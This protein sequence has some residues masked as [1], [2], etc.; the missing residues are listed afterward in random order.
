MIRFAW[1]MGGGLL[2]LAAL[3]AFSLGVGAVSIPVAEVARHL[4][5]D[6][7]EVAVGGEAGSQAVIV[8]ELRLPRVLLVVLVG[9]TLG[10]TGA[11]YQG[12]FRNPLADP[13][14]IGASSG[15]ALGATVAISSGLEGT[16]LGVGGV[17][18]LA[19]AGTLAAVAVISAIGGRG[20]LASPVTLILA[21]AAVST[22]L[23]AAVSFLM[24]LDQQSL[25]A[26]FSWLMGGF[27][28]R[29]W[30]HLASAAP[31]IAFGLGALLLCSRPLDALVLGEETAA[32]LGL[33]LGRARAVIIVA[34]SLATAAAVSVS[35]I[36]GF[37]GLIAPH[38]A[39][40]LLGGHHRYVLPASG[41]L[42]AILL[43]SADDLA[44]TVL[45]PVEVPVG[46]ITAFLGGPFFLLLLGRRRERVGFD[47]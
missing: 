20:T 29:G 45:A 2:L 10:T 14:V 18:W 9:A 13:F 17:S 7:A 11:A 26:I 15:A 32:G 3:V 39:R 44:R 33:D 24:L 21:G 46:I 31:L 4:L 25:Q 28:G 34:A 37:V 12:L 35:G 41:V 47:P 27:V 6:S 42:G 36:I 16:F 1:L 5:A 8:R 40:L 19:F 22:M 23:S 30:S 38:A 43:L